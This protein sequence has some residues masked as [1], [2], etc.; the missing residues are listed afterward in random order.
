MIL[1][2]FELL[3]LRINYRRNDLFSEHSLQLGW[4]RGTVMNRIKLP[5]ITRSRSIESTRLLKAPR[6]IEKFRRMCLSRIDVS[7]RNDD[8]KL[9]LFATSTRIVWIL[10]NSKLVFKKFAW[11]SI[12]FS[13]LEDDE[14]LPRCHKIYF[15]HFVCFK[16][17]WIDY[18]GVFVI[19][20]Q[21]QASTKPQDGFW[22]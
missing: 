5:L 7:N 2:T 12:D 6:L 11:M 15:H 16:S 8:E 19:N 14:T 21:Q 4:L 13:C 9:I 3:Q 10:I 1:A 22:K 17:L 18:V 20:K